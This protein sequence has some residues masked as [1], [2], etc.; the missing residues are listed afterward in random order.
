MVHSA[1]E[2]DYKENNTLL[3]SQKLSSSDRD[4]EPGPLT[5]ENPDLVRISNYRLLYHRAN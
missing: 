2:H 5:F 4:P 1:S 3:S